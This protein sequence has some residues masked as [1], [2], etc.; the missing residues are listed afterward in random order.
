MKKILPI[1]RTEYYTLHSWNK[2]KAPAYNLKIYNVIADESIRHKLYSLIGV[3]G[4]YDN[5]A[6]LIENFELENPEYT[7]GFNGRSNG[8]LVLY[9][10]NTCQGFTAE[11]TPGEVLKNFRKLAL[12]IV[13]TAIYQAKNGRVEDVEQTTTRKVFYI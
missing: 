2:Q 12:D 1:K 10:R 9:R 3:D 4:F 8:Y 6:L 7:A 5:I 11:Q 13:R